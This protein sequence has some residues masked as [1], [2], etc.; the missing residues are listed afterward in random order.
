M[1][2]QSLFQHALCTSAIA[3][4]R[5]TLVLGIVLGVNIMPVHAEGGLTSA[6]QQN[7]L[8]NPSQ[9]LLNAESRGRVTIYDGLE[10]SQVDRALDTQFGRI[11]KMMFIRTRHTLEDG[12]VEEDDD[13]D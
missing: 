11:D 3:I 1:N 13:C 9:S 4:G 12:T 7:M 8:F 6:Y 2:T 10:N 5:L